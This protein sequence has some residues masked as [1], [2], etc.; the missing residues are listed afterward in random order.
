MINNHMDNSNDNN[1][2]DKAANVEKKPNETAGIY[3]SSAIKIFDPNT[4][5]ILVQKRGDN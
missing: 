2:K 5:E 4:K 1:Q 3:F